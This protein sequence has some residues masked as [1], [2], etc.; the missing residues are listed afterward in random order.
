MRVDEVGILGM[1]FAS[2][3]IN[4]VKKKDFFFWA[5]GPPASLIQQRTALALPSQLLD[6]QHEF[7]S[8]TAGLQFYVEGKKEGA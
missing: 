2:R 5:P 3:L 8:T 4:V 1:I 6:S 7:L